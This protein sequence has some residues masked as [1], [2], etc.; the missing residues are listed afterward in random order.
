[1]TLGDPQA[2][3]RLGQVL[4]AAVVDHDAGRGVDIL[5]DFPAW[6]VSIEARS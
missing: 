2:Q 4:E 3:Q 1:M 6:R 5:L